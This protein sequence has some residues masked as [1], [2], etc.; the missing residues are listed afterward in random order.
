MLATEQQTK[1]IRGGRVGRFRGKVVSF[2]PAMLMAS[3]SVMALSFGVAQA[4]VVSTPQTTPQ[5]FLTDEDNTIAATITIEATGD[6]SAVSLPDGYSGTTVNNSTIKVI[7]DDD[8]DIDGIYVDGDLLGSIINDGSIILDVD[9]AYDYA[10][11]GININGTV[12]AGALVENNGSIVID[13]ESGEDLYAVGI[14]VDGDVDGTVRNNDLISINLDYYDT[15]M[16]TLKGIAISGVV[17]GLVENNGKISVTAT[18]EL[19]DYTLYATGI[20]VAGG[21]S[22]KGVVRNTGTITVDAHNSDDDSVEASGIWADANVAGL[23]ENTGFINVKASVEDDDKAD[24]YGLR[25]DGDV[26]ETGVINNSGKVTA[27]AKADDTDVSA[28]GIYVASTLDGKIINTGTV[29]VIAETTDDRA[30]AYGIDVGS[31][32]GVTGS[33]DNRGTI[34]VSADVTD[35]YTASAWG[36]YVGGTMDGSISNGGT[37]TVTADVGANYS[38]LAR[39]IDVSDVN[40][41]ITNSGTITVKAV[42]EDYYVEVYGIEASSIGVD[43]SITNSGTI[44]VQATANDDSATAYGIEASD[45]NGSITNSGT[46]TAKAVSTDDNAQAYGIQAST[47]GEFGSITNSGTITAQATAN[48]NGQTKAREFASAYGI[49]VSS[50]NGSVTNSGTIT[51][52][53]VSTATTAQAYGIYASTIGVDGSITNSGTI[54]VQATSVDGSSAYAY[55]MNA[56]DVNGSITNYGTITAKAVSN[57]SDAYAYGLYSGGPTSVDGSVTNSGTIMAEAQGV[58]YASAMGVR[59]YSTSNGAFVN[60][61]TIT[62]IGISTG[63][64][65]YATAWGVN[66]EG[67]SSTGSVTNSG[68]ISAAA[69]GATDAFAYG[70][71]IGSLNGILTNT[72]VIKASADSEAYAIYLESGNGTLNLFTNGTIEG[73]ILVGEHDVNMTSVANGSAYY[74]FDDEDPN[75]G[76]FTTLVDRGQPWFVSGEGT[77]EPIYATVGTT[78]LSANSLE[79]AG[80][81]GLGGGFGSE[82]V[83]LFGGSDGVTVS[84]S[85]QNDIVQSS[86]AFGLP[87]QFTKFVRG[88]YDKVT[89]SDPGLEQKI[90]VGGLF[91]GGVGN[92]QNGLGFG[93]MGGAVSTSAK[94]ANPGGATFDNESTGGIL[95]FGF[96]QKTQGAVFDLGVHFGALSHDNKRFVSTGGGVESANSSF[97]S[98]FYGVSLG[99]TTMPMAMAN[100]LMVTPWARVSAT[101]QRLGGYTE[102]GATANATVG[103]RKATITEAKI[104]VEVAKQIESGRLSGSFEILSRHSSGDGA[105]DVSLFGATAAGN[106]ASR[107]DS[108]GSIGLGYETKLSNGGNLDLAASANVVGS[109]IGGQAVSATLRFDF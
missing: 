65:Y 77:D 75:V 18:G 63:S 15:D 94:G 70:V 33:I 12:A 71:R 4:E 73:R 89:Y 78:G 48:D 80:I 16:L 24:A 62:A 76:V 14:Y 103:S 37:I 50:V 91:A 53:A 40:G 92:M 30:A 27:T 58:S 104:G 25:V 52:K 66:M 57:D 81:V 82:F 8:G 100:G 45:V 84:R 26:T 29:K 21:I 99:A 35:S 46:I 51:V 20:Y 97:N 74:E 42:S 9:D 47:I 28:Y 105:F 83:N 11:Y 109:G 19:T 86:M 34:T 5:S 61:G 32:I 69:Q 79:L 85:G 31:G 59:S 41:S 3:V 23:I 1:I 68:T 98:V 38:A 6:V 102:T 90:G 67:V 64:N 101:Q 60:S 39:G 72:G 93:V 54:T 13:M 2:A 106:T 44:T 49:E 43:G 56:S 96:A 22:E 87:D 95:Q 36:I 7:A 55:G 10:Y 88:S 107:S 17:N 108:F